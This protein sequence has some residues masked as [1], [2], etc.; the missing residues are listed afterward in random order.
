MP[1]VSAGGA[2]LNSQGSSVRFWRQKSRSMKGAVEE[3]SMSERA[4][5]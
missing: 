3:R 1:V 5:G 4:S 2:T